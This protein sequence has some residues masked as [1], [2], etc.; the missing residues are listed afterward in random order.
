MFHHDYF[1]VVKKNLRVAA[2]YSSMVLAGGM[3]LVGE[4]DLELQNAAKDLLL[5]G[6][7]TFFGTLGGAQTLNALRR[8]REHIQKTGTLDDRFQRR[9]DRWYCSAVG[10]KAAAIEQ[11]VAE[12]LTETV[13]AKSGLFGL[14]SDGFPFMLMYASMLL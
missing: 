4:Q 14:I 6:A 13:R 10:C 2:A 12:Q 1:T 9:Y 3:Y 5:A 8:T 7:W 11:G